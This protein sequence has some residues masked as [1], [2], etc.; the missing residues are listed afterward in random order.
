MCGF[1]GWM[2]RSATAPVSG[3]A[4]LARLASIR[5]RGPDG[6]GVVA[7]G[8]VGIAAARLAIQGDERGAQP[9]RSADGRMVLAFN[10]E[11]LGAE[12]RRLEG[13]VTA[14]DRPPPPPAAG[15]GPL[16]AEAIAALAA[17]D[18]TLTGGALRDLLEGSMGAF[19]CWD[20]QEDEVWLVRDRLG[21]KPLYALRDDAGDL[22]FA[23][24]LLPLLML[25]AG[26]RR[27]S[28]EGLAELLHWHRPDRH[29]PFEGVM[30][31]PPAAAWRIRRG[32]RLTRW[33]AARGIRDLAE[34]EPLPPDRAAPALAEAWR[35]SASAAADAHGSGRGGV[36]LLLSGGLD[37]G[38]VAL[39]SAEKGRAITGRF[40]PPGGPLDESDLAAA[41][42]DA[43]GWTH[44]IL[45][46]EDEDLLA[47]LP[48]VVRAL[49]VPLAGPG[50][51]ALWRVAARARAHGARILL[52]GTGGDELL[53]GYTR[54]A[55]VLGRQG[56][57]TQG[58]EPLARRLDAAG[59]D[60]QARRR[61]VLDRSRSLLPLL[62]PGFR[63][64]LPAVA[65]PGAAQGDPA[66]EGE[67]LRSLIDEEVE[68]TLPMLLHVE[69]RIAMAHGLEGRPVPCLGTVPAVAARIPPD[70]RIGPDGEGKRA[71]RKALQGVMPDVVR[72]DVRK[73]GFPTP[74]ARAART[75]GRT[76]VEAVL[77]DRRFRE[78]GWWNVAACHA[79][80][81]AARP[82]HDRALYALLSWE[83]WA[84]AFLDGDALPA[85]N[86]E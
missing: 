29:L 2:R 82:V 48:A 51:L 34:A 70:Q 42:A 49:E 4:L 10:G 6:E 21:I 40:A 19:A 56:V 31:V 72:L 1:L 59:S 5:H 62:D 54:T 55:L 67:A 84:R 20:R 69:D 38:A 9:L 15:D 52:T 24:Q 46:L 28:L 16:L 58:Y 77:A 61:E 7:E 33:E 79:L 81:D 73:R 53:G 60:L 71:L 65:L 47:D 37:S 50:A 66:A 32:G 85:T 12:A 26:Y 23:S 63:A 41:V 8:G 39:W 74:F 76:V 13:L 3:E 78:R 83:M 11:I 35:A 18:G 27:L 64:A 36:V 45:D 80:L 25:G 68:T 14:A 43:A 22:H 57:W 86:T 75:T 17:R 44:E 30:T